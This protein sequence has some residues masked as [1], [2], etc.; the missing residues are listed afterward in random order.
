MVKFFDNWSLIDKINHLQRRILLNSVIYY[1]YDISYISD[2]FYDSMC[3]QLVQLQEEYGD[4]FVDDS[5]FGYAFDDFD[6]STG[7][8][9]YSRLNKKDKDI[10]KEICLWKIYKNF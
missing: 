5:R 7:F 6:G 2:D 4:K 8:H 9:L 10:I 3:K 1:V